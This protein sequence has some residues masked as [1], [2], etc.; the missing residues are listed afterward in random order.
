MASHKGMRLIGAL[1]VC[2]VCFAQTSSTTTPD[3]PKRSDI[4]VPVNVVIA[5]TTVLDKSGNYVNGLTIDDFKLFDNGKPQRITQDIAF[6]PIS[7]VIAVEASSM[8]GDI[9]PKIQ[10]TGVMIS[11]LVVGQNGEAAVVAFDHRIRTLQD[12]T[13]DPGKVQLAMKSINPGSTSSR[14][15]DTVM[16]AVRMLKVRPES[17]RRVI[18]LISEKRDKASEGRLRDALTA[19]QFANVAI[20]S[21]DISHLMA[22]LTGKAQPPRPNPIPATANHM[23]PGAVQTPTTVDIQQNSGNVIPL[24]VEIFKATKSLFVDDTLDVFTRYTGGKQYSFVSNKSL[25]KAVTAVGEEIHS[26]YLLSYTPNNQ[27]E[28]GFHEIRVEVNRPRLEVRT[29]PG[30][31]VAARP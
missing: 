15:I 26:Q 28:G 3:L 12:F 9:L 21:I 25:E 7:L 30:Y 2:A 14:M 10:T 11:N 22:E 6:E 27:D 20:Y 31:W 23:P 19:A 8:L 17:R 5:P 16:E 13:D 29:R 24:F 1:T 4:I 18:L